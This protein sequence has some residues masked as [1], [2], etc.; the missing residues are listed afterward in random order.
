M[1]YLDPEKR[2]KAHRESEQ[3]RRE[4][5]P[6]K[7]K[8]AT[9]KWVAKNR[10]KVRLYRRRHYDKN[11]EVAKARARRWQRENPDRLW[12]YNL[13]QKY[14]LTPE[15]Y[16]AMLTAQD[17]RC[18]ICRTDTLNSK[19]KHFD[20]D[21]VHVPGFRELPSEEKLRYIRGLLCTACNA[22]IGNL[23]DDPLLTQAATVYL[24]SFQVGG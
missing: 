9:R 21:H 23:R 24:E 15:R 12:G 5:H 1:P 3:L 17:G 10:D 8:E 14:G 13:K 2:R 22:G 16:K 11:R 6:E 20:V 4:T 19:N 18:A 7:V